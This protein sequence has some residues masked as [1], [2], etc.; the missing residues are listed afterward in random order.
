MIP[1][2]S[3]QSID[4]YIASGFCHIVLT[5]Q[6]SHLHRRLLYMLEKTGNFLH[7]VPSVCL[8]FWMLNELKLDFDFSSPYQCASENTNSGLEKGKK[9]QNKPP[10]LYKIFSKI[11]SYAQ[12]L[13]KHACKDMLCCK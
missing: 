5:F 9:K 6:V 11:P 7:F 8:A 2:C 13:G 1:C 3:H 4:S 12:V 10:V